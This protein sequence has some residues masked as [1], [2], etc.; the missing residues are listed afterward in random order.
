MWGATN[1]EICFVIVFEVLDNLLYDRVWW[2][3][4]GEGEWM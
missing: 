1:E 4:C 2:F 3:K